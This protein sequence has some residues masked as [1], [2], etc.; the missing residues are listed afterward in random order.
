MNKYSKLI[1]S[2]SLFLMQ[3]LF[4]LTYAGTGYVSIGPGPRCDYNTNNSFTLTDVFA[5]T[6]IEIRLVNSVTYTGQF[7]PSVGVYIRGGYNHCNDANDDIQGSTLSVLNADFQG[8]A[9]TIVNDGDYVFENIKI[10]NG[11]Q[12]GNGGGGGLSLDANDMSLS[13]DKV[14]L[15][16]NS[17]S[18]GA[19]I[20]KK[21]INNVTLI[22]KDSKISGNS[23]A[24]FGGGIYFSGEGELVVYG[25]TE[26]SNNT[27]ENA[28][29][30]VLSDSTL[31]I[32]V[33]GANSNSGIFSNKATNDGGGLYME[34]GSDVIITGSTRNI[35]GIGQVGT[36]GEN[37]K[38]Y[39]NEADSDANNAGSGGGI[40]IYNAII[41]MDA[42]TLTNNNA[43]NGG[44]IYAANNASLN[45]S[46]PQLGNCQINAL[47]MG[48]N[49]ISGNNAQLSGGAINS[50]SSN[51]TIE[52]TNFNNNRANQSTVAQ[53]FASQMKIYSSVLH[54]NG[55]LG[56]GGFVDNSAFIFGG[57]S[58]VTFVH[59]TA[60]R[61]RVASSFI[62]NFNSDF[63]SYANIFFND[64][65]T[66]PWVNNSSAA[67]VTT[68]KCMIVDSANNLSDSVNNLVVAGSASLTQWFDDAANYDFHINENGP[69]VDYTGTNCDLNPGNSLS[70]IDIDGDPRTQRR[71][72]GADENLSND[73][74]FKNGF[75]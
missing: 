62:N 71:D 42:I 16:N 34:F 43:N 4:T 19:G 31:A 3:S 18:N 27:A 20:Y 50:N 8:T 52:A 67:A 28:G 17:A 6:A 1:L 68:Y 41:N 46:R 22:I 60:V 37:Y 23:A 33:G 44:G 10:I 63:K 7:T 57:N 53:L 70:P 39:L 59:L 40:Y 51:V 26:I 21:G 64:S 72:L 56:T 2:T 45:I 30:V 14:T 54:D 9:L 38:I 13:L 66:G 74:I 11:L 5:T 35:A 47:E 15:E 69:L 49:F 12:T 48:C 58:D 75:E 25:E 65:L 32:F 36:P 55:N 29:G 24:L 61:N 73:I